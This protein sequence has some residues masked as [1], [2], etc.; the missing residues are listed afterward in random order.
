MR[1]RRIP[2][3]KAD[4]LVKDA[5]HPELIEAYR[6]KEFEDS[7]RKRAKRRGL[8]PDKVLEAIRGAQEAMN[9]RKK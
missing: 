9:G 3:R 4:E 7:I 8:D 2:I 5:G 6:T 1:I